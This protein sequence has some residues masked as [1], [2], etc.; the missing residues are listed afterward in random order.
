MD[1]ERE[2]TDSV[3]L[4]DK[5]TPQIGKGLPGPGRPKGLPNKAT[6]RARE[7]IA[8]FVDGNV[9][10]LQGWLDAIANEEGPKVAWE[11]FMDVM[12]YHVPKLAR[13]E[14]TGEDGGPIRSE[15]NVPSLADFYKTVTRIP[16]ESAERA[17]PDPDPKE[18]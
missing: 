13:T 10:R 2:S 6:T 11:C 16:V 9:D 1:E 18:P 7:A 12:E 14:L 15:T 5:K 8:R 3:Q 17:P 4:P